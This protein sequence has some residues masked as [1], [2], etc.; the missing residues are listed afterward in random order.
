MEMLSLFLAAWM[1]VF[2][3]IGFSIWLV[4]CAVERFSSAYR[5]RAYARYVDA[6]TDL[7]YSDDGKKV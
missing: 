6:Q 5:H 2:P 3:V 7:F 1:V 4:S